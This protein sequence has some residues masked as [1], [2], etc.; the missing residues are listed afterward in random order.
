MKSK[1]RKITVQSREWA[2]CIK[3]KIKLQ[4]LRPLQVKISEWVTGF[5]VLENVFVCLAA[6]W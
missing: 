6:L 3:M 4:A 1:G 2:D 5:H